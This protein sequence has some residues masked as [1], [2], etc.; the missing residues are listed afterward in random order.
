M[1]PFFRD[2][3]DL[4]RAVPRAAKVA[5]PLDG[6]DFGET[7]RSARFVKLALVSYLAVSAMT[8]MMVH[9]VP[10]LSERG[11]TTVH[12]AQ[13]AGLA[14]IGSL[15]GRIATGFLLDRCSGPVIGGIGFSLP[16]LV[17]LALYGAGTL[18]W[19]AVPAAFLLG[20]TLGTEVDVIGYVSSRYFGMRNFGGVF[21][22]L[23]GLQSLAEGTGPLIAS[24]T[25]DRTRSYDWLLL[26][27]APVFPLAT[28]LIVS[29]GRY[30]EPEPATD[31]MNSAGGSGVRRGMD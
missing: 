23:I 15:V 29:L 11:F 25:F 8:A 31:D 12:A 17:L 5:P 6:L 24:V 18:P 26:G 14:G 1:I 3:R 28:I 20:V 2:A 19:V 7:V 13:I 21:G 27:V 4:A 10:I 30:P 16:I 22:T 9:M